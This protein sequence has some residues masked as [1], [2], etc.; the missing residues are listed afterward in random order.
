VSTSDVSV[1]VG[2][3][4]FRQLST[5]QPEWIV[6]QM[7]RMQIGQAWVGYL[8]AIMHRDPRPG[9]RELLRAIARHESRL[10]P[11]PT[12]DPRLPG[13]EEDVNAAIEVGAPAVRAYPMQQDLE[14]A[15]GEMRVLV[16]ALATAGLPL[17]LSVRFEDVRQRHPLDTAADLPAAA[18][19]AL[20]RCDPEVRILVTHADRQLVEEVHFGLVPAESARLLWDFSWIWGPPEN[21]LRLLLETVGVARFTFGSGMPLRIPDAAAAKLDLLEL[22]NS[23]RSALLCGNLNRWRR[24]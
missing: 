1:Y 8:P 11:V 23:D 10:L 5:T 4:P 12:V 17:V 3:Y 9:N 7:D 15:G 14:P 16:A 20:V 24:C 2:D 22:S 21:H 18:I 6:R 13:W 19:R